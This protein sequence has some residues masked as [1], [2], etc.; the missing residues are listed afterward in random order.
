MVFT[1][2]QL[3]D[4]HEIGYTTMP[5]FF[6]ERE[7]EALRAELD[8]FQR[9]GLIRNVST[10]GDGV[11]HSEKAKNLQ[12]IPLHDK[13]DLMRAMP[14]SPR[15]VAAVTE[16]IG[17][18][19]LLQLDQ[20]FLKPGNHGAGTSWHQD[21]HY[22]GISDPSKGVGVWTALH[23][24]TVANGTM[25]VVPRMWKE[26]LKHERDLKSDHHFQCFPPEDQAE[27]IELPAGGVLFFCYGVPHCTKGNTTDKERGALALH[28]VRE[29]FATDDL[30]KPGRKTNPVIAGPN[31]TGGEAE[32]GVKVAGTWEQEVDK[33]LATV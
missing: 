16:L 11:T 10:E 5:N 33:V 15:L 13:S 27:A 31:A 17:E 19:F 28:F 1:P 26:P 20:I 29:D 30:V 14:F 18:P 23:D 25:H 9:E 3:S 8:R 32:Y 22:F 2:K 4:F 7:V 24:S 6:S 21:N 12:V